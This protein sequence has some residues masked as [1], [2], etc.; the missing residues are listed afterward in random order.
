MIAT[1]MTKPRRPYV[2]CRAD[3]NS[4]HSAGPP[5]VGSSWTTPMIW[6]WVRY[7]QHPPLACA[8]PRLRAARQAIRAALE[9]A[10]WRAVAEETVGP[11]HGAT[12]RV[13]SSRP[14]HGALPFCVENDILRIPES[15]LLS[16]SAVLAL[17]PHLSDWTEDE[18]VCA[19]V[20]ECLIDALCPTLPTLPTDEQVTPTICAIDPS[21]CYRPLRSLPAC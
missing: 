18:A 21:G 11:Y 12:V 2:I 13:G 14:Y 15:S 4:R 10:Y 20:R 16:P 19:A 17:L 1:C 3:V 5:A 7:P 8:E 9:S 6:R